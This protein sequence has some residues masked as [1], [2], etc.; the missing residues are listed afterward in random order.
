MPA[1]GAAWP[2]KAN[3]GAAIDEATEPDDGFPGLP[4]A[5][6]DVLPDE[7]I[8]LSQDDSPSMKL[9]DLAKS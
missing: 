3:C 1:A 6:S 7:P 9:A 2:S 4:V 8:Q 5:M